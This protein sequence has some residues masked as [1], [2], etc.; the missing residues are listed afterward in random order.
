MLSL[1]VAMTKSGV[2]GKNNALPWPRIKE[3]MTYF[4]RTTTGHIVIL[5]RKT[6]D[7]IGKPLPKRINVV[8]TRQKDLI[9]EGCWVV[10]SLEQALR[11]TEHF[12]NRTD[13][14]PEVFIIGGSSLYQEA[15]PLVKKIY[16]TH[17]KTDYDGDTYFP[18]IDNT[19]WEKTE[20]S[21]TDKAIFYL[22]KRKEKC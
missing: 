11:L 15:M 7:S 18:E 17:I 21:E 4:R 16:L 3:D 14:D 12:T 1:I 19:K 13:V 6:Y 5:G 2:I 22:L 20:L 9:I 8:V 10:H